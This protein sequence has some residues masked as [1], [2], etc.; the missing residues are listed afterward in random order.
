MNKLELTYTPYSLKL[1]KTL[2]TSRTTITER[3]GFILKLKSQT[4][5]VGIGEAA[6]LPDFGSESYEEDE[7]VLEN[8]KLNL[9][10]DIENLNESLEE[11][12]NDYNSF[13][14]LRCGFELA[15]L[16]LICNE[17]KTT[18][19]ALL[20]RNYPDSI[21]INGVIG[22]TSL[23]RV[24]ETTSDLIQKG[25]T[26]IKVKMGRDDFE[27]DLKTIKKIRETVGYNLKLRI[28]ANAK[29]NKDEALEYLKRIES[30][31]IQYAEQ[32]VK[33]LTDFLFLK[34]KINIPL[35]ADESIRSFKDAEEFV[36]KKA[37]SFLIL[38]PMMLGGIIPTL[39]IADLAKEN[40]IQTVV[41]SSFETVIGRT[42]V[43]NTAA[44]INNNLAHGL[45]T[46]DYLDEAEIANPFPVSS[47]K[48]VF[49]SR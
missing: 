32:P 16:N 34:E 31:D 29:W 45:G 39:N 36:S 38:K 21:L 46:A 22:F 42:G 41:T 26:T 20:R 6:P 1:K 49:H 18:I 27:E 8:F 37:A 47:G 40:G 30:F 5:A 35:A 13:P 14:S 23:E 43:V 28:D 7:K 3:K 4:S 2:Q 17:R 12:L 25:F 9:R 24:E 10:V 48:I 15:I 44:F 33:D 19:P 11:N